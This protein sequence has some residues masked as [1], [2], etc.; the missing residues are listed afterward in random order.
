MP[1]GTTHRPVTR[2]DARPLATALVVLG[3]SG[4]ATSAAAAEHPTVR[5]SFERGAGAE[6]CPDDAN[7]REA[8]AARL[9]YD[10]FDDH[11]AHEL[12]A[13]VRR[14]GRSFS[15]HIELRD[16]DGTVRGERDLVSAARDCG[17]LA[18]A[19]AIAVSLGID[20]LSA[21]VHP[22]AA[23]LPAPP[24]PPPASPPPASPP[25]VSA[26]PP[27]PAPPPA[28]GSQSSPVPL[29]AR[30]G[31]GAMLAWGVAPGG[32][33]VGG[34]LDAGVRR[35]MWSLSVEGL[36]TLDTTASDAGSSVKST[37]LLATAAPC[38]H[39]WIGVG[40]ALVGVGSLR[41]TGVVRLPQ[42]GHAAFADGGARLGVLV[43]IVWRLLLDAH[44]DGLA[45]FTHL[46]YH[47]DGQNAWSTPPVWGS[48]G[49][50]AVVEL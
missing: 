29:R 7:L 23:P 28:P 24:P 12:R 49:L 27:P 2:V 18:A 6:Q 15:A 22:A 9:G 14:T 44:V 39:V 37:L 21:T 5:L 36:A 35:G 42:S 40:C 33:S 32:P 20:P 43:P 31:V 48:L 30:F 17:E 26:A 3:V 11:A 1:R 25:E 4:A 13:Q 19:M 41:A 45:T 16:A 47:L 34:T 46:T 38:V 8:V 10:P 50:G